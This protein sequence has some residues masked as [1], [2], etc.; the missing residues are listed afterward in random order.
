MRAV[1]RTLLPVT[2]QFRDMGT[3]ELQTEYLDYKSTAK[4]RKEDM[5][6]MKKEGYTEETEFSRRGDDPTWQEVERVIMG[7]TEEG[8]PKPIENCLYRTVVASG[9]LV[10]TTQ[11]TASSPVLDATLEQVDDRRFGETFQEFK[12]QQLMCHQDS[13]AVQILK[14]IS[15]IED[16]LSPMSPVSDTIKHAILHEDPQYWSIEN[17]FMV[18]EVIDYWIQL[19]A[20]KA[21]GI[22]AE[23][24]RN[25]GHLESI[26][27]QALSSRKSQQPEASVDCRHIQSTLLSATT[28]LV[29]H[30]QSL[31]QTYLGHEESGAS[32]QARQAQHRRTRDGLQY[33]NAEHA[34]HNCLSRNAYCDDFLRLPRPYIAQ[35]SSIRILRT[36]ETMIR[37]IIWNRSN[38]SL[39]KTG[40]VRRATDQSPCVCKV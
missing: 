27:D 12:K 28:C 22:A 35:F 37:S 4:Y 11:L 15:G 21:N 3:I 19:R 34:P 30:L 23:L 13:F 18:N 6:L 24:E 10:S 20:A 17:V 32:L 31:G 25:I 40:D 26:Q 29:T 7:L 33:G 36:L 2:K 14:L 5:D 8:V 38:P 16:R 39:I 1:R 9:L